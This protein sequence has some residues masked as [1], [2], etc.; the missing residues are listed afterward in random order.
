MSEPS[1]FEVNQLTAL[2][3]EMLIAHIDGAVDATVRD[4]HLVVTRNSLLANKML[5]PDGSMPR[6]KTTMLTE[7][8]RYALATLLAGYAEAL[9]KAGMLESR[10]IGVLA[11]IKRRR[12][13]TPISAEQALLPARMAVEAA[14][15]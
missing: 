10:P 7:R 3:R 11:H 6:P 9:V 13:E 15:K 2:Q 4:H 5:R 14:R 8:G 1:A 12:A